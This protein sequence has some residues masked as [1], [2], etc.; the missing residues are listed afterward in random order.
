MNFLYPR[1]FRS[2]FWTLAIV[3]FVLDIATKYIIWAKLEIGEDIPIVPHVFSLLH[4]DGLNKGALFGF[5]NSAETGHIANI[6]FSIIS[7]LAIMVIVGWSFNRNTARDRL[8]CG[9]LGLVLG[10]AAGNLYDRLVFGGVRDWLWFRIEGS[11]PGELRFNWPVFNIADSCL[12]CGAGLLLLHAFVTK[13][14][15]ENGDKRAG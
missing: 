12:V 7:A 6:I 5:G 10:G 4:Q 14:P 15:G 2:L 3:G 1:T 8:L 11:V 13:S 9:A